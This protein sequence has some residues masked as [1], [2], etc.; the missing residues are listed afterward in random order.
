MELF[1]ALHLGWLNGWLFLPFIYF[2]TEGLA[3]SLP[4]GISPRL[5]DHGAWTRK[6]ETIALL[7]GIP[8]LAYFALLILTPLRIDSWLLPIGM[9][10]FVVGTGVC[11]HSILMFAK[12]PEGEPV[13]RGLYRFS[14]N[15]QTVG[16]FIAIIGASIAVGSWIALGVVLVWGVFLHAR[17]LAEEKT[18]LAKYGDAYRQFMVHVPRYLIV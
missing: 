3:K 9:A 10:V 8:T 11:A 4:K 17:V 16:M 12:T 13:T 5:F 1:P 6:D 14:R 7:A 2:A 15:P 18:C